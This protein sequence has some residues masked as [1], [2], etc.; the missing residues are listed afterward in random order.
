MSPWRKAS[1]GNILGPTISRAWG[2]D[3]READPPRPHTG[4]FTAAAG[5]GA[6]AP[7]NQPA[8]A[9]PL[10][11]GRNPEALTVL[12]PRE[13]FQ[14]RVSLR[15]S[16]SRI[17]GSMHFNSY[18]VSRK[19]RIYSAFPELRHCSFVGKTSLK[20]CQFTAHLI[21]QPKWLYLHVALLVDK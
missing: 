19:L 13:T 9:P 3:A 11:L 16:G 18:P 17:S 15:E 1:S 14:M 8:G 21:C 5:K 2:G 6:Q 12:G 20:L 7:S 4:H 10:R